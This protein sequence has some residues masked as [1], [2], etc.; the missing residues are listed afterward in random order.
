MERG[1]HVS[2]D[3]LAGVDDLMAEWLMGEGR[4]GSCC[5][6]PGGKG[7]MEGRREGGRSKPGSDP[8]S[9]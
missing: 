5:K 2:F 6:Q 1:S 3:F 4:R 8:L 7:G 9:D